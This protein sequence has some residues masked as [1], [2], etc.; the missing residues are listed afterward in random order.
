MPTL[1]NTHR[2]LPE[3]TGCL[4][5]GDVL[6]SLDTGRTSCPLSRDLC[7]LLP[8]RDLPRRCSLINFTCLPLTGLGGPSVFFCLFVFLGGGGGGFFTCVNKAEVVIFGN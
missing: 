6:F 4:P 7:Y 5:L 2:S 1:P 8:A 3:F